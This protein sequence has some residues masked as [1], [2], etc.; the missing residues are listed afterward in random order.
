MWLQAAHGWGAVQGCRAASPA[1]WTLRL[2]GGAG[3]EGTGKPA[4]YA[5]Q[6]APPHL[7]HQRLCRRHLLLAGGRGLR[8]VQGEGRAAGEQ[9]QHAWAAHRRSCPAQ[10]FTAAAALAQPIP[11]PLCLHSQPFPC[12]PLHPPPRP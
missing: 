1:L 5:R 11:L 8:L 10:I 7:R 2:P 9:A 3:A 6:G 4:S 12:Y